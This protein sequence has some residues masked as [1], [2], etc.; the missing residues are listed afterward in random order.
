MDATK[1]F[2]QFSDI[3]PASIVWL[4]TKEKGLKELINLDDRMK[5]SELESDSEDSEGWEE[6]MAELVNQGMYR[7]STTLLRGS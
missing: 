4:F 2:D 1:I 7:G 6:Y 5:E 3:N